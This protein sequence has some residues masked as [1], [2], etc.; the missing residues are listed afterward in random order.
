VNVPP[1]VSPL[2]ESITEREPLNTH[3]VSVTVKELE[4]TPSRPLAGPPLRA[5]VQGLDVYIALLGLLPLIP[6]PVNESVTAPV[7]VGVYVKVNELE[8]F[9]GVTVTDEVPGEPTFGVMVPPSEPSAIVIV[10]EP[11]KVPLP[12]VTV[13]LAPG[14]K[15]YPLP[16][17]LTKKSVEGFCAKKVMMSAAA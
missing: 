11:L 2:S 4:P 1:G 13:K 17:P 8:P 9:V 12:F 3:P 5:I 10:W 7:V 6:A 15:T 16:G 14:M